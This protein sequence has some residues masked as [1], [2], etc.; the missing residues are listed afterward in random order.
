MPE[1]VTQLPV[2]DLSR[3]DG[4]IRPVAPT[5]GELVARIGQGEIDAFDVL[6][7]R[8][9]PRSLRFAT[10]FLGARED[11]EEAVQDAFVR[12]FRHLGRAD[13]DRFGAYLY[14]ILLNRCRT[15][16]TRRL[17][18]RRMAGPLDDGP[19]IG[20]PHPAAADAT[21]DEIDQAL[22]Q[23]KPEYREAFLLKHVDDMSYQEMQQITGQSIPALKM[24]V[25][26]ACETLR[27][28]LGPS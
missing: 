1:N 26:R 18:W 25:S 5:D 20:I 16:A 12:A 14:R 19:D 8:Y 28:I 21:R 2:C 23:L 9:R 24:R 27:R 17:W 11:A 13:P 6:V 3:L 10:H 22:A 7:A 4:V 15:L